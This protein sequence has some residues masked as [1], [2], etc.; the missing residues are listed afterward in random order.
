MSVGRIANASVWAELHHTLSREL[1][2]CP[3]N[4]RHEWMPTGYTLAS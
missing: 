4:L 2:I 1:P 3:V